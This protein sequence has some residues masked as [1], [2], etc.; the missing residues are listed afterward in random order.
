MG[1]PL[2]K[3]RYRGFEIFI[4]ESGSGGFVYLKGN[5]TKKKAFWG[6]REYVLDLFLGEEMKDPWVVILLKG[7]PSDTGV[8]GYVLAPDD[9]RRAIDQGLLGREAQG[10]WKVNEKPSA[11]R[12]ARLWKYTGISGLHKAI[13]KALSETGERA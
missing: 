10:D 1:L 12:D 4:V 6:L 5:A 7:Q 3:F 2:K 9:V 8:E 11:F 13:V